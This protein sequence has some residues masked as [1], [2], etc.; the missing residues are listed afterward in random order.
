MVNTKLLEIIMT[1][2]N[3]RKIDF[4]TPP[5]ERILSS[6]DADE[7]ISQI[8]KDA[9]THTPEA[10]QHNQ[11]LD[12]IEQATENDVLKDWI[13]S[14]LLFVCGPHASGKSALVRSALSE[15]YIIFDTG[16]TLRAMHKKDHPE[17]TFGEWV[18]R[19]EQTVGKYFTDELLATELLKLRA[20]SMHT[21]GI[22]IVGNRSLSGIQYLKDNV[23][24]SDAKIIYVD[25]PKHVLYE[26][27]KQR[28][29]AEELT[30]LEFD[31]ILEKDIQLGLDKISGYCD[32]EILNIEDLATTSKIIRQFMNQWRPE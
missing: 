27:Y 1:E 25:A 31:A 14:R 24:H 19:G 20:E 26:R 32:A 23:D 12:S 22:V 9:I 13:A 4:V 21:N 30:Q 7:I 11:T 2:N 28:E 5:D 16:P 15:G 3:V 10:M 6:D 17:L 29:I 18:L 8:V